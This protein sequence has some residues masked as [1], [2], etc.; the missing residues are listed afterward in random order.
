MKQLLLL[1][2]MI[3]LCICEVLSQQLRLPG[4]II[5]MTEPEAVIIS[6]GSTKIELDR[7]TF[8]RVSVKNALTKIGATHIRRVITQVDIEALRKKHND[9]LRSDQPRSKSFPFPRQKGKRG[10]LAD[11]F[12]VEFPTDRNVE[13]VLEDL[14][15]KEAD[16]I[17]YAHANVISE[18]HSVDLF[19][20]DYYFKNGSNWGFHNTVGPDINGPQAWGIQTGRNDV[21]IAIV[22][23]GVNYLHPDLGNGIGPTKKVFAGYDFTNNDS[24]PIPDGSSD[25]HGSGVAGIAA[26]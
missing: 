16:G 5:V 12:V 1:A 2:M 7:A 9:L 13:E 6:R 21:K 3:V 14:K 15:D 25:N 17:I 8:S 18:K 19:P 10:N 4:Q 20:N 23:D 26:A 11:L 22:D 24:D